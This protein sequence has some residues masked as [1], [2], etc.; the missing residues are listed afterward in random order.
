M[1]KIFFILLFTIGTYSRS[2]AQILE[3]IKAVTTKIIKAIDLQVQRL[4][5]KTIGLQNAQKAIENTLSKLKLEEIG[6]WV[7]KQKDLYQGFFEELGR[8]KSVIAYYR[9]VTD[10]INQQKELVAQYKLSNSIVHQDSHF[11]T[12]ELDYITNIYAGI[13][14]ESVK[15]LDQLLLVINSFSL[16]ISDADRLAV[17]NKCADNIDRQTA[18]LRR[19]NNRNYQISLQRA[20]DVNEVNTIKQLYGF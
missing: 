15:N 19:F 20:R 8:V 17:I 13:L 11:T 2:D 12:S 5:N 4:Q 16:Q 6:G 1:K 18:D 7:Q 14:E 9:R 10:I 3:L